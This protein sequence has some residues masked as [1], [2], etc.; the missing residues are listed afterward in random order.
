MNMSMTKK[1]LL[2]LIKDF[3]DNATVYVVM[4]TEGEPEEAS[5]V[6]LEKRMVGGEVRSFINI[7]A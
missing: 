2:E 7:G 4:I 3:P 6:Q 5:Y 1:D